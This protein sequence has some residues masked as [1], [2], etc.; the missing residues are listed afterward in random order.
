MKIN[1]LKGLQND[2]IQ[3]KHPYHFQSPQNLP[4][5]N[6]LAAI[7]GPRGSGKSN[8]ICNI[9]KFYKNCYNSV[10][11]VCPNYSNELKLKETFVPSDKVFIYTIPSDETANEIVNYV[12]EQINIYKKYLKE[13]K[14][15]KENVI[16]YYKYL[17]EDID[18]LNNYEWSKLDEMN[19]TFPVKPECE[20]D[21]YPTSLIILDD[22]M[23]TDLFKK[24]SPFTNI[25]IR[26][27]HLFMS[28]IIVSQSYKSILR[29]IRQNLS[30]LIFFK[31]NDMK[32]CKDIF[33]E[34]GRSF[35][36]FDQFID[37]LEYAT[38][39]PFDFLYIDE[40]KND[41]RKNFNE[42]IELEQ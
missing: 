10:H 32:L 12:K 35:K 34:H 3:V 18:K 39:K 6:Y 41:I 38:Q 11:L 23:N 17:S 42:K 30:W 21:Y 24:R 22:C 36:N 15:Y 16:I 19:Y 1:R 37:T 25:Q 28:I 9:Y 4:D 2:E 5:V 29:P 33:D 8:V 27:R 20:Y 26:N 31:I 7:I 13:M 14:K 40:N